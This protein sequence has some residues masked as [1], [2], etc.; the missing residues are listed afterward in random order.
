MPET[1][2]KNLKL[3]EQ[4]IALKQIKIQLFLWVMIKHVNS[5]DISHSNKVKIHPNPRVSTQ[6]LMDYVK[7][8]VRK[9][10]KGLLIHKGKNDIQ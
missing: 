4:I 10:P 2:V 1:I 7:P 9:K 8:A 3:N 5:C 6:D